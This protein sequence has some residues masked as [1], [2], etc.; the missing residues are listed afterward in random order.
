MLRLSIQPGQEV[1]EAGTGS[2]ALTLTLARAI[3]ING[4]IYS[5]D[6]REDMQKLAEKNLQLVGMNKHVDLKTPD[7]SEGFDESDIPAIFLM[8]QIPGST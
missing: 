4:K 5:Y 2:G 7:I 1:I 6:M 8:Y 3:G